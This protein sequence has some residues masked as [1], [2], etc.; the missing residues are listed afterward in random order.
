MGR[1][2]A[3]IGDD[4]L[5]TIVEQLV[6]VASVTDAVLLCR[7]PRPEPCERSTV[8]APALQA[9]GVRVLHILPDGSVRPHEPPLPFDR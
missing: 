9:C 4:D 2:W 6:A 5:R 1:P 3:D 8:L 7:E